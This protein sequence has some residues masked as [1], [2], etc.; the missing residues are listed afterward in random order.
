MLAVR[1]DLI[2]SLRER[3][4]L[5]QETL[6]GKVGKISDEKKSLYTFQ[7]LHTLNQNVTI[8]RR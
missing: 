5:L 1:K 8:Q 4:V 7:E 3:L 6:E 2:G